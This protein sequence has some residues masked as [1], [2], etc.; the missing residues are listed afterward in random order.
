MTLQARVPGKAVLIGEYAVTDGLPAM[1]M[2]LDRHA[3]VSIE[4]CGSDDCHVLAPQLSTQAY[5]FRIDQSNSLQWQRDHHDW[6]AFDWTARLIE[7]LLELHG[8][9]GAGAGGLSPFRLEIDTAALYFQLD[10]QRIK[11]GLGSS[12]AITVGLDRVLEA[13]LDPTEC[14]PEQRLLR[15][16]PVYRAAQG[17]QGSGIDLACSIQGGVVEF[18]RRSG[19]IRSEPIALPRALQW[20]FAW[21]G[22]P[23]STPELLS[24]YQDWQARKPV[25]AGEWRQR[26]KTLVDNYRQACLDEDA[27]RVL[28]ALRAYGHE[29]RTIG[30]FMGVDLTA[31]AHDAIMQQAD[32]LGLAAK[33]SGAGVG[34]LSIIAGTDPEAM[35]AMRAWL[36][37]RNVPEVAMNI[38]LEGASLL[39][40]D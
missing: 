12:S 32:V 3:V 31:G 38:E 39:R 2:A 29:M 10:R 5:R 9:V 40:L 15:L 34:D 24:K 20:L 36:V 8:A 27:S 11:L 6:A 13:F 7:R 23:A 21:T 37:S 33:P 16:L 25:A 30:R 17:N 14:T 28:G 19:A 26:A 18:Q 35:Q 1:V 22:V 4:G